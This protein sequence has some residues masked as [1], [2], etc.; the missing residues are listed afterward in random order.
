MSFSPVNLS[1]AKLE[2]LFQRLA[3]INAVAKYAGIYDTI[4]NAHQLL[5][6]I[7]LSRGKIP[8]SPPYLRMQDYEQNAILQSMKVQDLCCTY[9][10]W[11]QRGRTPDSVYDKRDSQG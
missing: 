2:E 9:K 5:I 11:I 1:I 8:F 7:Q 4:G 3:Y 6:L 10:D